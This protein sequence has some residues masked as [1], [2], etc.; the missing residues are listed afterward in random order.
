MLILYSVILVKHT[1]VWLLWKRMHLILWM[2]YY[3]LFC[4]Q[5]PRDLRCPFFVSMCG[6]VRSHDW[7]KS[8]FLRLFVFSFCLFHFYFLLIYVFP[9]MF[10]LLFMFSLS[11]LFS[12]SFLFLI[13]FVFPFSL[14][15]FITFFVLIIYVNFHSIFKLPE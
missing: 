6:P 5:R 9:F 13:F 1:C 7:P 3:V 15:L 10:L 14:A 4:S 11:C 8:F 2:D 12:L